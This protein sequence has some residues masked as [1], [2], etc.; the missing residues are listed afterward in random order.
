MESGVGKPEDRSDEVRPTRPTRT[1]A[2]DVGSMPRA[3]A[4]ENLEH[5]ETLAD[6][7]TVAVEESSGVVFAEIT[8]GAGPAAAGAPQRKRDATTPPAFKKAA[9]DP[10]NFD[11]TRDA[12][13]ANIRDLAADR[14]W[15][16]VDQAPDESSPASDPPANY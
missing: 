6:G 12:G 11:Q 5:S 10:E 4:A 9:A 14:S 3:T 15:D 2:G 7:R 16:G 1:N 8:G 13:A